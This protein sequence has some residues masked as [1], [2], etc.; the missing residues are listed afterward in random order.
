MKKL[1]KT[2]YFVKKYSKDVRKL[3]KNKRIKVS[4]KEIANG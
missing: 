2:E 3:L 4:A 1:T